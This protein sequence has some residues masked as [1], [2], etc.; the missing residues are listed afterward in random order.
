MNDATPGDL[1]TI[2]IPNYGYAKFVAETIDSVIAQDHARIELLIV[3][4]GSQDNSVPVIER[5][6]KKT[7]HL[8][9][10]QFVALDDNVGKLGA[11]NHMLDEVNGRYLIILD[12][13]DKLVPDY[14]SR[15]IRELELARQQEPSIGFIYTDCNL[16]D[17]GGEIIDRGRSTPF[18]IELLA[19]FS[20]VPEPAVCLAE[21]FFAAAPFDTTIRIGTK[22]HKWKR[23]VA[24]GWT[25]TYIPE[26]LFFY[27]MHDRNM[28]GIGTRVTSEIEEG[29]QGERIL[30]GYWSA[31]SA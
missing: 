27:R 29:H 26:P 22:H 19:T 28:S 5:A 3:D 6:L 15:C 20:Y 14:C 24:A 17:E 18:D 25:G 31:I 23:M 7:H 16:M 30:S 1:L 4:D 8:E 21:A 10:V 13:D 9:R 12:S 11:I 2:L